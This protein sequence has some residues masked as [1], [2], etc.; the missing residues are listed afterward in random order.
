MMGVTFGSYHSKTNWGLDY[1]HKEISSPALKTVSV[2]LPLVHG[3][4]DLTDRMTGGNP[5]YDNRTLT[6]VFEMRTFR[7]TWLT[8]W[9]N[10]AAA[11]HGKTLQVTLDEDSSWYWIGRVTV[12]A[13]EDHGSTA[14]LTITVDAFPFKWSKTTTSVGSWNSVG[15]RTITLNVTDPILLPEFTVANNLTVTYRNQMYV[16][17]SSVKS[18]AGLVFRKGNSQSIGLSGSGS[19]SFV[20]RKGSL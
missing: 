6:F 11:V 3:K 1:L 13:L 20:Y 16:A 7:S 17:T 18:P 15:T 4:T 2:S 5:V 9:S 19:C 10:I 14:G 12:G 8:N